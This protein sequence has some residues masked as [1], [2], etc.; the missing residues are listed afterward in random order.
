[1]INTKLLWSLFPIY[2]LILKYVSTTFQETRWQPPRLF[3]I[4]RRSNRCIDLTI[5]TST[6]WYTVSGTGRVLA[7]TKF[8][9]FAGD[10]FKSGFLGLIK[11]STSTCSRGF[12]K[13]FNKNW[14]ISIEYHKSCEKL[15]MT[16]LTWHQIY[17]G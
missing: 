1:M 11:V 6:R 17:R 10:F 15:V 4:T 16:K 7:T 3:T 2:L 5:P 13:C 8:T 14:L 12:N 9:I